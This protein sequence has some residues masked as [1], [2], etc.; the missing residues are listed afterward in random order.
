MRY[1][2]RKMRYMLVMPLMCL[3]TGCSTLTGTVE[4]NKSVC[5]VWKDIS[6]SSKDTTQ[7]ILEVK[8]NNARRE[9]YCS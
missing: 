3:L 4:T 6:W 1:G 7:T 2:E 9:G 8:V 5:A